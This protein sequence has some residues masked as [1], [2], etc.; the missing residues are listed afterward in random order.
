MRRASSELLAGRATAGLSLGMIVSPGSGD[1]SPGLISLGRASPARVMAVSRRSRVG[2]LSE[3]ASEPPAAAAAAGVAVPKCDPICGGWVLPAGPSGRAAWPGFCG[4]GRL[5][6]CLAAS[7]SRR[8]FLGV[9]PTWNRPNST[10]IASAREISESAVSKWPSAVACRACARSFSTS[11][12]SASVAFGAEVCEIARAVSQPRV[13]PANGL[14]PAVVAANARVTATQP[15]RSC[16][17]LNT[18]LLSRLAP[19]SDLDSRTRQDGAPGGTIATTRAPAA[20]GEFVYPGICLALA[21]ATRP[22]RAESA[23]PARTLCD[24]PG[25]RYSELN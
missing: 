12:R 24:L 6:W 18:I 2:R 25:K 22:H 20:A 21:T 16:E 3:S 15:G 5:P 19:V 9:S 7:R 8:A 17:I 13:V 23:V 1:S 14:A 11:R 10:F 4:I